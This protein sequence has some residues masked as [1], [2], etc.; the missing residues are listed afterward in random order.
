ML[1][2]WWNK[3]QS[4]KSSIS[5]LN[6]EQTLKACRMNDVWTQQNLVNDVWMVSKRKMRMERKRECS[7]RWLQNEWYIWKTSWVFFYTKFLIFPRYIKA[8]IHIFY[9]DF[10]YQ[11]WFKPKN[12]YKVCHLNTVMKIEWDFSL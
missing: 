6:G 10:R 4:L 8:K 1:F 2:L 3:L 7:D 5:H 11:T 12:M 9:D